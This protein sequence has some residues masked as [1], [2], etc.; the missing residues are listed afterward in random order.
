MK[1]LIIIGPSGVGKGTIITNLIDKYAH[2][3]KFVMSYTTRLKRPN[4]VDGV[5]YFFVSK[6]EF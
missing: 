6:E 3:F 4:E 1:S 2:L 5:H